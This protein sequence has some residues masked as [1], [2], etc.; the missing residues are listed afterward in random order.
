[1]KGVHTFL[2]QNVQ[3][4]NGSNTPGRFTIDRTKNLFYTGFWHLPQNSRE[5]PAGVMKGAL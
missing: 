4:R 1:M 3:D 5:T 2:H